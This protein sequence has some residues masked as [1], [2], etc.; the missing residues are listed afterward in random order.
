MYFRLLSTRKVFLLQKQSQSQKD[1]MW[2]AASRYRENIQGSPAAEYL[3][4]RKLPVMSQF[5]LGYVKDPLPGHE[6]YEGCLSIPY[7]RYSAWSG[8]SAV[9]IR[10]RRLDD[11]T[12]KYMTIA[13]DHARLFNTNALNNYSVDMSI[14]EGELDAITATLAGV[15]AVGMPGAQTWKPFMAELFLGYR[16]VNILADGDDPGMDFA[17][18]VAKTLPNSRIIQMPTGLDVNSMVVSQG[19]GYLTERLICNTE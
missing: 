19:A 4:S 5:G 6:M 8:W 15:P 2:T 1:F 16:Y 14:T 3:E 12:P 10:F 13:G 18:Q 11:V 7:M 17:R 9:S